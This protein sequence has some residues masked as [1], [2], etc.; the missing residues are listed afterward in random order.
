MSP[1]LEACTADRA[2]ASLRKAIEELAAGRLRDALAMVANAQDSA[3]TLRGMIEG[4]FPSHDHQT[5]HNF[6][7]GFG[8]VI[9][10]GSLILC[11]PSTAAPL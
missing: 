3:S 7:T 10:G 2:I 6:P 5:D 9:H 11:S 4:R 1:T 8:V